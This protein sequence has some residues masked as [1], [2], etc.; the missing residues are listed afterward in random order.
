MPGI[1]DDILGD[2]GMMLPIPNLTSVLDELVEL[3]AQLP[4]V[5]LY[6]SMSTIYNTSMKR[7][8]YW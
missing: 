6:S 7:T 8:T 2:G 1:G 5:P 3:F 4:D